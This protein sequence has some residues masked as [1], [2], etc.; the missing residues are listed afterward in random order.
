MKKTVADFLT[1]NCLPLR[2]IGVGF[3]GG[4]DSAVLLHVLNKLKT[5]LNFE[6]VALHFEHGVRGEQSIADMNFCVGECHKLGVEIICERAGL[7]GRETI[8]DKSE[9]ALRELRFAFFERAAVQNRLD[10]IALA[11]HSDDNAETF[12]L[13]LIRGSGTTGMSGI[14]EKRGIFVRPM[15]ALSKS[16]IEH[17]AK[18]N[19]IG[20]VVDST[21]TNDKYARNFVRNRILPELE[22]LNPTAAEAIN[23]ASESIFEADKAL[24]YIADLHFESFAKKKSDGVTLDVCELLKLPCA[25]RKKVYFLAIQHVCGDCTDVH[26]AHI[27]AIEKLILKNI[28]GKLFEL[29]GKFCVKLSYDELIICKTC[30]IIVNCGDISIHGCGRYETPQYLIIIE[31]IDEGF[32]PKSGFFAPLEVLETA[33]IRNRQ[34]GDKIQPF[35]MSEKKLLSDYFIDKKVCRADRGIPVIA[36]DGEVLWTAH[37]VSEK[38]RVSD[39]QRAVEIVFERKEL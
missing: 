11:H 23:R 8:A 35:G 30:G 14:P 4:V 7:V 28:T 31:G 27:E 17:Y 36:V 26:S 24:Q 33:V 12:L 6:L 10:F 22:K 37:G 34:K 9:Q 3:S 39:G 15:L 20:Y 18:E 1:A 25:V 29:P 13:N 16:E 38:L 21:N 19:K 2:R 32:D 5:E